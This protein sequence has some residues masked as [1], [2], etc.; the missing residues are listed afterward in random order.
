MILQELVQ[1]HQARVDARDPERPMPPPGWSVETIHIKATLSPA[2]DF[3]GW[4]LWAGTARAS[5]WGSA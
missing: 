3:C 4:S 5:G 1:C 2:A